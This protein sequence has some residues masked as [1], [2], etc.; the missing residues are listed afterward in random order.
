MQFWQS[1]AVTEVDQLVELAQIAEE[2]GFCGVTLADHLAKPRDIASRYPYSADGVPFWE[3]DE[4]FPD[5]WVLIA[6]LAAETTTLRFLPY[7]YVLPMRDPFSVAKAVSTAA[8]LSG[9]RVIL[10]A[11]VGWMREEFALTGHA[12]EGR[13]PRSDEMLEVIGK[14]LSGRPVAHRGACYDFDPVQMVPVSGRAVEVRIG[15]TTPVALRRAARHDGWLGLNHT[16]QELERIVASLAEQRA[17]AGRADEPFDVMVAHYP[18]RPDPGEY[19][20]YRDAG[21]TSIHVPPWRYRGL[22]PSGLDE[23]R[24]SLETFAERF[25]VPLAG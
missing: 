9:D 1:I 2:V 8:V 5:P 13:G 7:V 24:R 17:R 16:P 3:A 14:L 20:R 23:K 10:G 11:G 12:Y 15:G 18:T 21:A 19:E 6:A 25:I 22:P 4:P